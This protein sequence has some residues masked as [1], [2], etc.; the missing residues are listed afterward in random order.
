MIFTANPAA[1]FSS[2]KD[3]IEEA[4][5]SV[6]RGSSYVLGEKVA[7]FERLFAAYIGCQYGVGVANGTDA[8][9]L[10]LRAL[11]IAAGDEVITVAHTAVATVAAI[12]ACGA[13]PVLVD[14]DPVHYT[15]D[16]EHLPRAL[17]KRT[18]AVICVHI[19]GQAC[20]MSEI[21]E[22]CA[23]HGLFL[24]EDVSQAHGGE[25][26]NKKLGSFGDLAC[27]S[28]YP[29]KNLGALGDA[30]V[31]TT[32]DRNLWERI[33][34]IR[35]YGWLK[36]RYNSEL[37]G[38][39]SRLDELQAAVLSVKLKRLDCNNIKR[40]AIAERYKELLSKNT[41]ITL[42]VIRRGSLHAMHLYVVQLSDRERLIK[43]A[44]KR[45]VLFGVHYPKPIHLQTAY[46]KR[47]RIAHDL[48]ITENISD[49][50]LSLP[51]YP[52]LEVEEQD[53]VCEIIRKF[54][55]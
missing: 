12:E 40:R 16:P 34:S 19:Y 31:I 51:M 14:I 26:N 28:C 37:P 10:S 53:F 5:L 41:D 35:Q 43:F 44:E 1:Q 4:I 47:I 54:Y 18:K 20:E 8:L 17:T 7:E 3:E 55:V 13:I 21:S 48:T 46:K 49:K 33:C 11:N 42:P 15:L 2:Q 39:N 30:G 9:E 50:I 32:N 52:E 29:T 6:A 38:R 45:G 22:F 25:Y 24:I 27:F 23:V 36:S